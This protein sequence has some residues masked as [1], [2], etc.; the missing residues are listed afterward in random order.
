MSRRLQHHGDRLKTRVLRNP[1]K[2][3]GHLLR[4]SQ[5]MS[6]S[7]KAASAKAVAVVKLAKSARDITDILREHTT[8]AAGNVGITLSDDIP[9]EEALRVLDYWTNFHEHVGFIIGDIINYGE[10]RW[11]EKY[12]AAME[13]TG[14]AK[15]TL[16]T[17]ASVALR[18]PIEHRQPSLG[19]EHHRE[20]LKLGDRSDVATFVPALREAG[21][22]A[23]KGKAPTVKELRA[24]V[25]ERAPIK[26]KAKPRAPDERT[27]AADQDDNAAP[28]SDSEP[29]SDLPTDTPQKGWQSGG[30]SED[31][32][33]P[34]EAEIVRMIKR[35]AEGRPERRRKAFKHYICA[36]DIL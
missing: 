25:R 9:L 33:I 20:I 34:E 1:T 29:E 8:M 23:E 32:L 19:F 14:R 15:P 28:V 31:R 21:E 24:K 10:C 2:R 7:G 6:K 3:A 36:G 35:Y 26:R 22:Q 12:T 30:L 17:Y 13:Q 4:S 27:D 5:A 11:G 18:I 16:K